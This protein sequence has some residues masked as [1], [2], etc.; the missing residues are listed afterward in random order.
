MIDRSSGK[1]KEGP[2][3]VSAKFRR[4]GNA[5]AKKNNARERLSRSRDFRDW[6]RRIQ[7]EGWESTTRTLMASTTADKFHALVATLNGPSLTSEDVQDLQEL[8]LVRWFAEQLSS[9]HRDPATEASTLDGAAAR[10]VALENEEYIQ[11]V[12]RNYLIFTAK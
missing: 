5:S 3:H 2:A 10:R 1:S 11:L 7:V 4:A 9:S 12:L 8:P 6:P